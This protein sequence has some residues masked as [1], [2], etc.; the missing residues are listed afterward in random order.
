[1]LIGLVSVWTPF[2]NPVFMA[3]WFAFPEVLYTLPVPLA[4]AA[5]VWLLFG[6][7]RAGRDVQPFLAAIA[8]FVL[9]FIGLGISL[10]PTIVPPNITIWD[11]AAPDNSLTFLLVG[12]A[13]LIPMIIAYM[14][15]AYW[16]FRGKIDPSGYYHE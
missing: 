2:L 12:A 7:L 15:H 13:I 4:V 3:R 9:C 5:A 8:L 16:V 11:A 10:Y 14:A 6:G 1:V